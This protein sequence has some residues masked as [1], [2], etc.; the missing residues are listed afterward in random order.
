MTYTHLF[1]AAVACGGCGGCGGH[2]L[3]VGLLYIVSVFAANFSY[4]IRHERVM[5]HIR[6]LSTTTVKQAQHIYPV[7]HLS[8]I[9]V[10]FELE[11][12]TP[13]VLAI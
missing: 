9:R 12:N 7:G 2:L 10:P 6:T 13:E 3:I 4:L 1:A 8:R 11:T 5:P